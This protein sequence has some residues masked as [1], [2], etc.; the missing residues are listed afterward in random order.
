[1]NWTG[2]VFCEKNE[3]H[4]QRLDEMKRW[5]IGPEWRGPGIGLT[6]MVPNHKK[7]KRRS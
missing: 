1:M 2:L 7:S 3:C 5:K 6:F 4:R